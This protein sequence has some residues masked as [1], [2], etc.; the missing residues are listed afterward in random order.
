MG[1][2]RYSAITAEISS[3]ESGFMERSSA[4]I[5]ALSSWKTPRVSPLANNSNVFLSASGRSS[6]TTFLPW[7]FSILA[8]QS[9]RTERFRK[10]K[11]SI[12]SKPVASHATMSNWVM[13]A[14]SASRRWIG[15]I[16]RSGS[17]PRITPAACTPHWRFKPSRP[18]A[19]STITFA[20]GSSS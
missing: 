3:K 12:L 8:R 16:S 13:T 11:K 18:R 4:R 2:G 5:G 1:P 17:R 9:S 19:V 14:P 15:M 6:S 20:L 7:F 10:P